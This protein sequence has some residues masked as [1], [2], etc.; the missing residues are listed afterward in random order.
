MITRW[1]P[2]RDMLAMQN[3]LDRMFDE[4]WRPL[5]DDNMGIALD[6]DESED[7]YTVSAAIPGMDAEDID[8]S[9]NDNVLTISG[10]TRV[11]NERKDE[12]GKR[13]L[14]RERRY[15]QFSRSVRLVNPVDADNI[16]ATYENGVLTL[17]LPK[18]EESKPRRIAVKTNPKITSGE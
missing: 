17:T 18:R 8:V 11:E 3:Q 13:V 6:I 1:N 4:A 14:M 12:E 16:E 2:M 5:Y 9:M 15:G 7:A 10:E